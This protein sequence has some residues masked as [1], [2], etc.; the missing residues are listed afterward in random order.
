MLLD[1]PFCKGGGGGERERGRGR[2]VGKGE[3]GKKRER[4]G[5]EDACRGA[6]GM[7]PPMEGGAR[8][9]E[10]E[11]NGEKRIDGVNKTWRLFSGGDLY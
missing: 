4:I 1:E 9:T 7:T 3:E 6:G 11:R 8:E 10:G 2:A 5:G